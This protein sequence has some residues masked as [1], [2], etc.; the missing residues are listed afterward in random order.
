MSIFF[1]LIRT[2][3][4][5][6]SSFWT[7]LLSTMNSGSLIWSTGFLGSWCCTG[8]ASPSFFFNCD[9]WNTV[10]I[11]TSVGNSNYKLLLPLIVWSYKGHKRG[12]KAPR[13]FSRLQMFAYKVSCDT[14]TLLFQIPSHFDVYL[15][16]FSFSPRLSVSYILIIVMWYLC[17]GVHPLQIKAWLYL[18][19]R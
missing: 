5:A 17:P 2:L 3:V 6:L 13:V 10:W 15:P 8:V 11:F 7:I 14:P 4:T 9:T 16:V 1:H 12:E 19:C 18:E